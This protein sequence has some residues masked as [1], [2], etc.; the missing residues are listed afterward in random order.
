MKGQ[1]IHKRKKSIR[2]C[3]LCGKF[4]TKNM[5]YCSSCLN[6]ASSTC[7]FFGSDTFEYH[8]P[9]NTTKE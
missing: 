9:R 3:R 2:R 1:K 5:F 4:L 7:D 8:K 6:S